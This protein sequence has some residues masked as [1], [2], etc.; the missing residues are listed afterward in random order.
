ML[1]AIKQQVEYI[2]SVSEDARNSDYFLTKALWAK[3]YKGYLLEVEGKLTLPL[4]YYEEV[5]NP[6]DITRARR[7]I[8]NPKPDKGYKGKYLPSSLEVRK[9]RKIREEDYRRWLGYNP[10]LREV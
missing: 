7:H 1:K 9:K 8:Q 4:D 3:Y 2:L 5:A 6:N 10:E